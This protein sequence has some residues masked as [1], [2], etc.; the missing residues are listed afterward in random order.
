MH[1]FLALLR[2]PSVVASRCE[3]RSLT[4]LLRLFILIRRMAI[5][6]CTRDGLICC[7]RRAQS[8]FTND[9]HQIL[10][11]NG[12]N[13]KLQFNMLT[14]SVF[15]YPFSVSLVLLEVML[16]LFPHSNSFLP[17]AYT[18]WHTFL[19]VPVLMASPEIGWLC[20]LQCLFFF[21][22]LSKLPETLGSTLS[23][24]RASLLSHICVD[25][26]E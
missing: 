25:R 14:K 7:T 24:W 17:R 10:W 3:W 5:F 13:L 16:M 12:F 4:P 9:C 8:S 21:C 11:V 6:Y 22:F 18:L 1:S 2:Y 23:L 15:V 20:L 19:F 26:T